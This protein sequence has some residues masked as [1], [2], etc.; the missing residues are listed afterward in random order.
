M[1]F[2]PSQYTR[3]DPWALATKSCK[4]KLHSA[5]SSST[6]TLLVSHIFRA[7][8]RHPSTHPKSPWH[9]ELDQNLPPTWAHVAGIGMLLSQKTYELLCAS[10]STSVKW[11]NCNYLLM[12]LLRGSNELICI[13]KSKQ[14]LTCCKYCDILFYG[15]IVDFQ[16]VLIH[17]PNIPGSYALLLFI[18][19][20]LASITSHIHNWVL[21]LL[22]LHEKHW[23]GWSTSWN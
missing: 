8:E 13:K 12:E 2:S 17:G 14:C 20:D 18:A 1:S 16:F 19:S 10:V 7:C 11:D 15:S 3:G 21:F 5:I 9:T 23:A 22:W 6:H 4:Y